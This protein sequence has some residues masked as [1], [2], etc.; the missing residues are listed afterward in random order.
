MVVTRY[1]R[2]IDKDGV[3]KRFH[4]EDMCQA[5][6]VHPAVKYQSEG[7]PSIE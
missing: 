7:G 4:Q 1:D 6:G 2:E 5:L 3:V